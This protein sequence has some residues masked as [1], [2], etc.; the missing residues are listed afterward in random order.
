MGKQL[1][2]HI[3][4]AEDNAIN[5]KLA[6][7]VLE[8]LGYRADVA[9]NGL[10]VLD[11]INRQRYDVVLMDM[12]MPEMDGLDVTRQIRKAQSDIRNIYIIAMTANVM[13]KDREACFAAGMNDFICKPIKVEE[14]VNA[15]KKFRP[16][17]RK[18][19]EK[20]RLTEEATNFQPSIIDHQN[21][22]LDSAAI[23]NLWEIVN[24]DAVNLTKLIEN[25]LNLS[26]PRLLVDM[27]HALECGNAKELYRAAL[28]G[29]RS[30]IALKN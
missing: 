1:P 20:G 17:D 5:Q 15:L 9:G 21:L 23:E 18:P 13:K 7:L 27:R 11:A 28:D 14:L 4:L 30:R 19:I 29:L 16:N 22:D 3:L 12:Q 8:R 10:E 2:L 25:F 24:Q 6:L 26:G